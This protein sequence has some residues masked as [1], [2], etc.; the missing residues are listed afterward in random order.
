MILE[1]SYR[2]GG[3]IQTVK[4]ALNT[5]LGLGATWFPDLYFRF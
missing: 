3:R 2:L 1:A 4:G 5:P